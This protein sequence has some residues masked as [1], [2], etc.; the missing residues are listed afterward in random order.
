MTAA[1]AALLPNLADAPIEDRL[2]FAITEVAKQFPDR[3]A[4]VADAG[5]D[6]RRSID[7]ATLATMVTRLEEMLD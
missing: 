3:I 4:I 1:A 6:Q 2:S 5:S 7:Y